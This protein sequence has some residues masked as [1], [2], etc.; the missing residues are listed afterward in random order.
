MFYLTLVKDF[1]LAEFYIRRVTLRFK[2]IRLHN[3][4]YDIDVKTEL[5][6][7]QIKAILQCLRLRK[8]TKKS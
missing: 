5:G 7:K 3:I 4:E 8:V 2:N 6:V 1:S